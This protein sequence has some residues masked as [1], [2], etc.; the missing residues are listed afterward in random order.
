MDNIK[1]VKSLY[2]DDL[3]GNFRNQLDRILVGINDFINFKKEHP[4]NGSVPGIHAG[5]GDSDKRFRSGGHFTN[6]ISGI[7]HA[8][9]THNIS[10]VYRIE[11]GILYLYGLYTH[12]DI[13]TGTPSN[14]NRQNQ[15]ATRWSNTNFKE[16]EPS[17]LS[18][19][20]TRDVEATVPTKTNQPNYQPKSKQPQQVS[21]LEQLIMNA[22]S[23]WSQR[24][25][26][27]KYRSNPTKEA[28]SNLIRAEMG[29]INSIRQ[30]GNLY[31]NQI[32]YVQSLLNIAKELS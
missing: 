17:S 12:D 16:L 15:M 3:V 7:S 23:N 26:L 14:V 4:A 19:K 28:L 20:Q 11:S 1:V 8:H 22:D 10:I 13:G 9:L 30:R 21:K 5:Y 31:P 32:K 25:F 24:N 27:E 18:P 6:K 29:Y 2:F